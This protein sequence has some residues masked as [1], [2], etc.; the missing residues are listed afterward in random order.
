VC[1]INVVS[2]ERGRQKPYWTGLK[3]NGKERNEER[4]MVFSFPLKIFSVMGRALDRSIGVY[5]F[6]FLRD[7]VLVYWRLEDSGYS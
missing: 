7:R 2:M 3:R 6:F 4:Q 5:I 1:L